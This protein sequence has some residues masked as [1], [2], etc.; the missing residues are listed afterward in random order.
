M[1]VSFV[2]D[3]NLFDVVDVIDLLI[4]LTK[5]DIAEFGGGNPDF[6]VALLIMICIF[7]SMENGRFY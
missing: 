3:A 2:A 5:F 4:A 1:N 6:D 7:E